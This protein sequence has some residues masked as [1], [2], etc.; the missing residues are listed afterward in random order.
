[1]HHGG[2]V[3]G[4]KKKEEEAEN[5]KRI[6][7]DQMSPSD[8]VST[9]NV[10]INNLQAKM[11]VLLFFLNHLSATRWERSCSGLMV[12]T[13]SGSSNL[14]SSSKLLVCVLLQGSS[15]IPSHFMLTENM[16]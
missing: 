5:I 11:N 3:T 8:K 16:N 12:R 10:I 4:R 14:G 6:T 2:P 1:L 9:N 15:N 7:A 13:I